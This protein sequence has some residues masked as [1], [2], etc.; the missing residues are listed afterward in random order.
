MP[1]N[2]LPSSTRLLSMPFALN[3]GLGKG[4]PTEDLVVIADGSSC[5]VGGVVLELQDVHAQ[6]LICR[7]STVF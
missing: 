7:Y 4:L 3:C 1:V 6:F 2:E 5:G